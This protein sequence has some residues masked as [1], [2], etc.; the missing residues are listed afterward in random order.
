[1]GR[2]EICDIELKFD[3]RVLFRSGRIGI[4]G[5]AYPLMGLN[6]TGKTTLLRMLAGFVKPDTGSFRLEGSA[7][8]QPQK[9]AVFPMT[10]L[11][12]AMLGMENPDRGAALSMLSDV[13]LS[14]FAGAQAKTLSGG[15]QQRLCLCRSMLAGGDIFLI[16]EPFSAVDQNA[17]EKLAMYLTDHCK[18]MRATLLIAMHNLQMAQKMSEQFLLIR[19]GELVLCGAAAV[20][21][22]FLEEYDYAAA[23]KVARRNS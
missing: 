7:L 8:Y 3:E 23:G 12:N 2:I 17:A 20:R 14:D 18:R 11:E 13:G 6:G 10:A 9:P 15:E 5:G 1:M 16:D 19:R 21:D 4:G 22:Y